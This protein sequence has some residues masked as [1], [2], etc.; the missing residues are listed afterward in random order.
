MVVAREIVSP[1]L[2]QRQ[3]HR[4]SRQWKW[5][6]PWVQGLCTG[7]GRSEARWRC[8]LGLGLSSA[9]SI[10]RWLSSPLWMAQPGAWSWF[11]LWTSPTFSPSQKA[12]LLLL[13]FFFFPLAW[14]RCVAAAEW[15]RMNQW[16]EQR[17]RMAGKDLPKHIP[18]AFAAQQEDVDS[19]LPSD[20]LISTPPSLL[21]HE[22]Q[23]S[24]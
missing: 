21:G 1:G 3:Q 10:R 12:P 13:L 15:P 22:V 20:S 18:R 16:D 19:W 6:S 9:P 4:C 24:F 11:Y 17:S 7:E 2:E 5:P 23:V 8:W 14:F